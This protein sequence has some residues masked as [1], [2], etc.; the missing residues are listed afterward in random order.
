MPAL[1]QVLCSAI[2]FSCYHLGPQLLEQIKYNETIQ[3]VNVDASLNLINRM[4]SRMPA[5]LSA[6]TGTP[7]VCVVLLKK[8]PYK[9]T[10]A[11]YRDLLC[12]AH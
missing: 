5:F 10:I 11:I 4:A 9:I 3:K 7:S 12:A 8:V 6:L 2:M 1:T